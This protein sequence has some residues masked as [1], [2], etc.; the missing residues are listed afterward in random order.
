MIRF[1]AVLEMS[2]TQLL[3]NRA[4]DFGTREV[5]DDQFQRRNQFLFLLRHVDLCKQR[6]HGRIVGPQIAVKRVGQQFSARRDGGKTSLQQINLK[7]HFEF[8]PQVISVCIRATL[9]RRLRQT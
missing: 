1:G 4:D 7:C 6:R 8:L 5:V 9:R 3:Q 2:T